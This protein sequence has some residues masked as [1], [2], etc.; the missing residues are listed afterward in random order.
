LIENAPLEARIFIEIWWIVN[1]RHQAPVGSGAKAENF[2][3]FGGTLKKKFIFL[4][5]F[6]LIITPFTSSRA[7][8]V[9]QAKESAVFGIPVHEIDSNWVAVSLFTQSRLNPKE[10][11]DL[12]EHKDLSF[13]LS[14]DPTSSGAPDKVVVGVY[15]TK[16]NLTGKF[17]LIVR[18]V[19]DGKFKKIF[20]TY[21]TG[22]GYS[23]LLKT[24]RGIEYTDCFN[25]DAKGVE[26]V[27]ESGNYVIWAPQPTGMKLKKPIVLNQAL[28]SSGSGESYTI[29]AN[30]YSKFQ[31]EWIKAIV[32]FIYSFEGIVPN[33]D[34]EIFTLK[35]ISPIEMRGNIKS[36]S[37]RSFFG[38]EVMRSIEDLIAK[39]QAVY[40]KKSEILAKSSEVEVVFKHPLM[41][42]HAQAREDLKK[43]LL[44]KFKIDM[45]V[46][47]GDM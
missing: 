39:R 25:C 30:E 44:K 24:S 4:T 41:I 2:F 11:Q 23:Y 32:D 1:K 40:Q 28:S 47:E 9:I 35:K 6:T 18:P 26:I 27:W 8:S 31:V 34:S 10:K 43:L 3:T 14:L 33:V 12:A 19:K 7:D 15:K 38:E 5:L 21:F 45:T 29:D 36:Q 13:E 46:L 42:A 17:L 22:S 16:S 20:H 37:M